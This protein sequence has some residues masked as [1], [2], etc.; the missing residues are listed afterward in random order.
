M[1]DNHKITVEAVMQK[2]K[3]TLGDKA[4]GHDSIWLPDHDLGSNDNQNILNINSLLLKGNIIS[5]W[6]IT[7]HRRRIGRFII[8]GKR[9]VR[10]LLRWYINPILDQQREFNISIAEELV[11]Q[12]K[13]TNNRID[14]QN[15]EQL[16]MYSN[17]VEFCRTIIYTYVDK[18]PEIALAL[19]VGLYKTSGKSEFLELIDQ[20]N[21]RLIIKEL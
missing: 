14:E 1:K 21:S 18:D 6:P 9:L 8:F 3:E 20:I 15:K 7:S 4:V 5:E 16:V 10:K 12:L 11:N 17:L 2:M 13:I 19:A